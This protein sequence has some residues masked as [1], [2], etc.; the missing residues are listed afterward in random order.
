MVGVTRKASQLIQVQLQKPLGLSLH[1]M[2]KVPRVQQSPWFGNFKNL[3]NPKN[4]KIA[5][6]GRHCQKN[7]QH[8]MGLMTKLVFRLLCSFGQQRA[9][10]SLQK[11]QSIEAQITSSSVYLTQ[12]TNPR[13]QLEILFRFKSDQLVGAQ[14]L[15]STKLFQNVLTLETISPAKGLNRKL[16]LSNHVC[17]PLVVHIFPS[18]FPS[19]CESCVISTDIKRQMLIIIAF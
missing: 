1:P 4:K 18:C 11:K 10:K 6:I 13:H 2:A 15:H 5:I 17:L 9:F 3:T 7:M 14:F 16:V 19:L 12:I 8:K